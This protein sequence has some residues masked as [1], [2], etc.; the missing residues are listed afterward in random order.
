MSLRIFFPS[1]KVGKKNAE[2]KTG[3]ELKTTKQKNK[4]ADRR[5]FEE[6]EEPT[7]R[8]KAEQQQGKKQAEDTQEFSLFKLNIWRLESKVWNLSFSPHSEDDARLI[9]F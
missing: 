5:D 4:T 3:G 6:V 7:Q 9:R 8:K 2:V 1:K